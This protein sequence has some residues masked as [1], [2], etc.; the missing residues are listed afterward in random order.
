MTNAVFKLYSTWKSLHSTFQLWSALNNYCLRKKYQNFWFFYYFTQF[1]SQWSH[2][3][4]TRW[5]SPYFEVCFLKKQR[6][7]ISFMQLKNIHCYWWFSFLYRNLIICYY[8]ATVLFSTDGMT[9]N[10]YCTTNIIS[11]ELNSVIAYLH[12]ELFISTKFFFQ[13]KD[14]WMK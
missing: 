11:F 2:P 10:I 13:F 14:F 3:H 9:V 12:S 7:V 1:F 6:E 5:F 8:S 4:C